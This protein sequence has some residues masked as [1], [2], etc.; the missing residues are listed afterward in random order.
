MKRP[1]LFLAGILIFLIGSGDLAAQRT[2]DL[3]PKVS[4]KISRVRFYQDEQKFPN[5]LLYKTRRDE[6]T[7]LRQAV[8]ATTGS[9]MYIPVRL[10]PNDF[11]KIV[12]YN[13]KRKTKYQI[14]G[15]VGMAALSY[16]V[17]DQ[18]SHNNLDQISIEILNQPPEHRF[19]EPIV[20]GII[21][22]GIGVLVGEFLSPVVIK[23][24]SY[25][26]KREMYARIKQFSYN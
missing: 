17:V 10:D 19:V 26:N 2:V 25:K 14:V 9:P 18:L 22:A 12:I 16:F 11:D 6:L 5:A 1:L 21:G 7:V 13:R 4:K 20:A 8:D 15:G 3:D 23:P 24:K